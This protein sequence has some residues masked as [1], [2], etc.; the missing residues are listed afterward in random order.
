ML[1]AEQF[2]LVELTMAK[3]LIIV[4]AYSSVAPT[5]FRLEIQIF[6]PIEYGE[7]AGS[8]LEDP[9]FCPNEHRETTENNLKDR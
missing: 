8:G 7:T 2:V 9:K 1:M 6:H 5:V 4:Y 3:P